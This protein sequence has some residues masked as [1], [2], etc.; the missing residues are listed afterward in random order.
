[1]TFQNLIT[2]SLCL[3]TKTKWF[4][5]VSLNVLSGLA[6]WSCHNEI[7]KPQWQISQD[8]CFLLPWCEQVGHIPVLA[9][10]SDHINP[11][12]PRPQH[13]LPHVEEKSRLGAWGPSGSQ[14]GCP[15]LSKATR[16]HGSGME[17]KLSKL[18]AGREDRGGGEQSSCLPLIRMGR[19]SLNVLTFALW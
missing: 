19:S 8:I 17:D 9:Q 10:L 3:S 1:M 14:Q 16:P 15:P 5:I 12:A 4:L 13:L 6:W 18:V 11:S 2:S 7:Y